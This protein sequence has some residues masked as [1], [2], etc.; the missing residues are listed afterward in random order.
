M[1]LRALISFTAIVTLV[2]GLLFIV[3]PEPLMAIYGLRLDATT[4]FLTRLFGAASV[5]IGLVMWHTSR[6]AAPETERAL[7]LSILGWIVVELVVLLEG[8]LGGIVNGLGWMFVGLD[9]VLGVAFASLLFGRS[10]LG[11]RATP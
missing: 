5:G 2:F 4:I 7:A 9:V 3:V 11:T 10:E 6:H 8:Q 1:T